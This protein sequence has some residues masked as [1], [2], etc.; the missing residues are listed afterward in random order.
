MHLSCWVQSV[1]DT[2][3]LRDAV[4]EVQPER[5]K[6]SLRMGQSRP[7][8]EAFVSIRDGPLAATLTE[9]Q[10]RVVDNEV[11]DFVLGGV[12]L[13]VN[14]IL[15]QHVL[16]HAS[17]GRLN[18]KLLNL[19]PKVEGHRPLRNSIYT[20]SSAAYSAWMVMRVCSPGKWE[21]HIIALFLE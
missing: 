20:R 15:V 3:A 14:Y 4:E 18:N 21:C 5:V 19:L 9:A 16:G 12:A 17:S 8:Y 11:K 1:K 7:L 6:L 13:E 2:K 10:K